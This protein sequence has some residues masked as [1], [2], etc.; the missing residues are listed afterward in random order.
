MVGI[1]SKAAGK[2]ENKKSKYNGYEINTD[3]DLNFYESF[4]R[5]HDPQLGRFWQLDPKSKY[6]ESLYAAMG[7]NPI[8][9]NDLLG[10]TTLYYNSK[11]EQIDAINR[12]AGIT[13]V[14]V[15]GNRAGIVGLAIAAINGNKDLTDK[16]VAAL[17]AVLQITGTA[18]DISAFD[19]FG[20]NANKF[21]LTSIN[22][23]SVDQMSDIKINGKTSDRKGLNET[24]AA[25][26]FSN[27]VFK[28]G[29]LTVETPEGKTAGDL[30]KAYPT[31]TTH[32]HTHSAISYD[33]S[34]KIGGSKYPVITILD[35]LNPGL[36]G[37]QAF[38]KRN[39][40]DIGNQPRNVVVT[41]QYI[42]LINGNYDPIRIS[43]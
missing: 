43:R 19:K 41:K 33:I 10:D 38:A 8:L 22:E 31:G 6:D 13:A 15:G 40:K 12:G 7:N 25:E 27:L 32:I 35:A 4:Y 28:T 24:K 39:G 2:L 37:D 1:S 20:D 3:F 36:S 29:K 23:V 5:T 26:A 42:Y 14:E 34:Y 9:A 16:Q 18:Y 17:D 30:T 11:G 21:G